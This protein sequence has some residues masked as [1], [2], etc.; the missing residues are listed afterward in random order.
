MSDFDALLKRSF[1]EAPEPVDNG[2]TVRITH[3]V[4]V[5]EKAATAR[6]V[7]WGVTMAVA[8]T[9]IAAGLSQIASVFAPELMASVG[10]E[11]ARAHAAL[12]SAPDF[13]AATQGVVQSLGMGMTQVLLIAAMLAAGGA[14]AYRTVRE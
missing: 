5:H 13:Q 4:E 7:V 14:V 12:T 3:A 8:G 1:A 10:L 6:Q 11:V 9:A 2:F